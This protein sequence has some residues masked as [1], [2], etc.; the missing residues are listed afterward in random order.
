MCGVEYY[1]AINNIDIVNFAGKC[2]ELE[3]IILS[4]VTQSQKYMHGIYSLISGC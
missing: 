1:S 4:E 2:M 3:N